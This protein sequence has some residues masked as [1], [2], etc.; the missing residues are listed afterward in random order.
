M[1]ESRKQKLIQKRGHKCEECKLAN[2]RNQNIPLELHHIVQNDEREENLQ[3]LCPNCH[4]LTPNYRGKGIRVSKEITDSEVRI[5]T[6]NSK[7]LREVLRKLGLV[8][9]GGNYESLRKRLLKLNLL[10]R[11]QLKET[12]KLCFQC[13]ITIDGK[14]KFCSYKCSAIFNLN[15]A[16]ALQKTKIVWPA[17]EVV[18]KMVEEHSFL[19]AERE[20]GVTDNAI[21]KFLIKHERL[22]VEQQTRRT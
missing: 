21:R 14:K 22:V 20:L 8:A 15:G 10:V 1:K 13:G 4:A 18:K 2:W 19:W 3:L 12:S 16:G 17:Y 11:F 5:A 7:S 9:K 6:D